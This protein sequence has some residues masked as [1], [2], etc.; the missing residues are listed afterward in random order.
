MSDI[1]SQGVS[2]NLPVKKNEQAVTDSLI[3]DGTV[4][5]AE[6]YWG[7]NGAGEESTLTLMRAAN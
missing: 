4:S 6:T 1:N 2:G 5:R 7:P 3:A